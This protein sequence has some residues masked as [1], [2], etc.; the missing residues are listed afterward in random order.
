MNYTWRYKNGKWGKG[1]WEKST[2]KKRSAKKFHGCEINGKKRNCFS[3][4]KKIKEA[5]F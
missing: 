2:R 3:V 1:K 5:T 4:F